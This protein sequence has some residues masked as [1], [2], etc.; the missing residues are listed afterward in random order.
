MP[1][2]GGCVHPATPVGRQLMLKLMLEAVAAAVCLAANAAAIWC[3]KTAVAGHGCSIVRLLPRL[4]CRMERQGANSRHEDSAGQRLS[5]LSSPEMQRGTN[6]PLAQCMKKKRR[7]LQSGIVGGRISFPRSRYE[8]DEK[9]RWTKRCTRSE[10]AS[11]AFRHR[12]CPRMGEKS[13]GGGEGRRII[14][15]LPGPV[16]NNTRRSRSVIRSRMWRKWYST[17][18]HS[19]ALSVRGTQSER[20]VKLSRLG[21]SSPH[22]QSSSSRV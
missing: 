2:G 4:C 10:N 22:A 21:P 6:L 12:H 1:R 15:Q 13:R 5:H 20:N 19:A 11:L 18:S 7:R 8:S 9:Q 16:V 14:G 3:Q 17:W